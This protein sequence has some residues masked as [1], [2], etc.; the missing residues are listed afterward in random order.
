[1]ILVFIADSSILSSFAAARGLDLLLDALSVETIFIPPMEKIEHLVFRDIDRLF[2][3]HQ[4]N[5]G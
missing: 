3:P 1:V 4:D 5:R 2:S